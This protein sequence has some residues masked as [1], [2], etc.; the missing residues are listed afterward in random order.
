[1]GLQRVVRRPRLKRMDWETVRRVVTGR[2]ATALSDTG[3][4]QGIVTIQGQRVAYF[5]RRSRRRTI[6]LT[7]DHRGLRVGAPLGASLSAIES[8]I[9]QHGEWVLKRLSH[10]QQFSAQTLK[11]GSIVAY[12]GGPLRLDFPQGLKRSR[13]GEGCLQLVL[14]P[15]QEPEAALMR[16]LKPKA[17]ALFLERLGHYVER[18]GLTTPDLLLSSAQTRWGSC[19]SRGEIRLN[20]RLIH[21]DVSLIDYVVVHELA[22]LQE[23]NHSPRFWAVVEQFYPDWRQARAALKQYVPGRIHY[24]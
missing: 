3:G 5:L 14:A 1:M 21:L 12:L 15:G 18:M 17:R 11:D 24:L 22:H 8:L 7:V 19:N 2:A 10:W 9:F 6:G 23:M 20:W 4:A 16:A 13:W